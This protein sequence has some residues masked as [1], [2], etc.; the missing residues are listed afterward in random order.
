MAM[1]QLFIGGALV[2]GLAMAL[3]GIG[4]ILRRPSLKKRCGACSC[5]PGADRASR[6]CDDK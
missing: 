2:F 5:H 4:L 3:M 6:V 1:L